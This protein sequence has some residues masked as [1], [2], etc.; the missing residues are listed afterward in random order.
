MVSGPITKKFVKNFMK[1]RVPYGR[2]YPFF[3]SIETTRRCNSRCSFCPI[4]N[5]KPEFKKGEMDTEQMKTVLDNFSEMNIIAVSYLGGEPTLKKGLP[6]V[7]NYGKKL[8]MISQV[9]TNGLILS[10]IAQEYTKEFTVIVVSLDTTDPEKYRD[11]R[12]IDGYDKVVG[13]I[14]DSVKLAKENDCNILVNTVVCSKNIEEIPEVVKFSIDELGASAIMIDFATYHD[15]WVSLTVEGSRYDPDGTDWRSMKDETRKLINTLFRMKKK[16]PIITSRSYLQTF[17]TGDFRFRCHPYLFC[18]V[19]KE[20]KVA[21]PCW[22]SPATKFFDITKEN[23]LRKLWFS[24]EVIKLRE[25]VRDCTT[26]YMHCIVE[27]SKVLGD[28]L[29]NLT[30][31]YEWVQVWRTAGTTL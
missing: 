5:E 15:Y 19:N 26:C 9:S 18:C 17:L 3:G 6:E 21:I 1:N 13:G 20:G 23:R 4:G 10:D 12:G 14:K 27:P 8:N 24:D 22:D 31:L 7:A 29:A 2:R 16:Y 30:D 11:I 28:P 25:K